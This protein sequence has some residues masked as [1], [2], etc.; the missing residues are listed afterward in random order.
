[1]RAGARQE[2]RDRNALSLS[3]THTTHTLPD[4]VTSAS[5]L[6]GVSSTASEATPI[7]AHATR[8][9]RIIA[10]LW[11]RER[12]VREASSCLLQ[13]DPPAAWV[14]APAGSVRL[15]CRPFVPGVMKDT[16]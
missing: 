9:E 8:K 6:S 10:N 12:R 14:A 1:M 13:G 7:T 16:C 3:H 2:E 4:W 5:K 15:L 11:E